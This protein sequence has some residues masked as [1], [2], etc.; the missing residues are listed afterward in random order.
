M[1][2]SEEVDLVDYY[3]DH[4]KF[5]KGT[6]YCS[7][8]NIPESSQKKP[9]KSKKTKEKNIEKANFLRRQPSPE[10]SV[11]SCRK[12]DNS[13]SIG[14]KESCKK[15]NKS[16][17]QTTLDSN[18]RRN[19]LVDKKLLNLFMNSEHTTNFKLDFGSAYLECNRCHIVLTVAEGSRKT[20]Q[21]RFIQ[22]LLVNS[23]YSNIY[24]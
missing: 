1:N 17:S 9:E 3:K 23:H 24:I 8:N 22:D 6:V 21:S 5:F 14:K 19:V 12:I 20:H 11:P 16:L 7:K 15:T 2:F 10:K 13:D 4:S 18:L